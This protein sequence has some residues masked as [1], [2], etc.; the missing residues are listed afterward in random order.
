[1][2]QEVSFVLCEYHFVLHKSLI[3]HS[4]P[5]NITYNNKEYNPNSL[6]KEEDSN[7]IENK[8]TD[9]E[10]DKVHDP[11]KDVA[12]NMPPKKKSVS[13]KPSASK[14]KVADAACD[15]DMARHMTRMSVAAV[16]TPP[17]VC[18]DFKFLLSMYKSTEE[19]TV[20]IYVEL[21]GCQLPDACQ[22]LALWAEV[23][24]AYRCPLHDV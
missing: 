3:H 20:R 14:K 4:V 21:V 13:S 5:D 11:K 2:E 9:I 7:E 12:V 15:D 8:D 23:L 10:E 1:V 18:L 17:S 16:P 24:C 6:D 22:G 19:A